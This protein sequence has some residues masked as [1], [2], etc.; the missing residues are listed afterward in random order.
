VL[1]ASPPDPADNLSLISLGFDPLLVS[2]EAGKEAVNLA[3]E[4]IGRI[5][6]LLEGELTVACTVEA[7]WH[8]D[9]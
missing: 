4:A 9:D 8:R 2:E 7:I 1:I 6:S 3:I 5:G